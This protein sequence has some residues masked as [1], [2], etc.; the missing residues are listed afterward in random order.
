MHTHLVAT[1]IPAHPTA[2]PLHY[3]HPLHIVAFK[4]MFDSFDGIIRSGGLL[5]ISNMSSA[6]VGMTC[7]DDGREGA[8]Y[9]YSRDA[10]WRDVPTA[11]TLTAAAATGSYRDAVSYMR[12]GRMAQCW[13]KKKNKSGGVTGEALCR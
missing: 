9:E 4:R 11:F 10:S 7:R 2:V 6:K 13:K 3:P 12:D 8:A 5:F 1:F